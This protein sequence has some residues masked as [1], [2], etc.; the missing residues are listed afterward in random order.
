M[1]RY[2]RELHWQLRHP[3]SLERGE[4]IPCGRRIRSHGTS[5][6]ARR[7]RSEDQFGACRSNPDSGADDA[8]DAW[9]SAL[10]GVLAGIVAWARGQAWR[11]GKR[12][13]QRSA[14][15]FVPDQ[16]SKQAISAPANWR[17]QLPDPDD[18]MVLEAA[19]NRR[20]DA[21]VT[22]NASHFRVAAARLDVRLARPA[23]I[24][25]EVIEA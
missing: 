2:N 20:A 24:I 7:G 11:S 17:P 8:G 3:G 14:G 6:L 18:E 23:D 4:E 16:A 12:Q 5:P 10:V 9:F 21:L 15:W 19:V 1:V 25:R 22:H 13:R